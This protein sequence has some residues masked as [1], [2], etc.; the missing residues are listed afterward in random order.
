MMS[1]HDRL[2]HTRCT[3]RSQVRPPGNPSLSSRACLLSLFTSWKLSHGA[4]GVRN[5]GLR[6]FLWWTCMRLCYR[7]FC[8]FQRATHVGLCNRC[9]RTHASLI[10]ELDLKDDPP[11][12]V[13]GSCAG[14]VCVYAVQEEQHRSCFGTTIMKVISKRME[15]AESTTH[16]E[17]NARPMFIGASC[18]DT[19][20]SNERLSP[21][22]WSEL[23]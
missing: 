19:D 13:Q 14:H 17:M 20:N 8:R 12:H 1:C 18:V 15:N 21:V 5:S 3:P 7:A 22:H 11:A 9:F 23:C 6:L 10:F 16:A 2:W 4:D